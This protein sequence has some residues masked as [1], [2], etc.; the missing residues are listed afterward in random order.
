M[1]ALQSEMRTILAEEE[2]SRNELKNL[3]N[4]LGFSLD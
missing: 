3:F 4:E 2:K 1:K